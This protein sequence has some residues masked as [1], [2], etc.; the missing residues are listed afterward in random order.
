MRIRLASRLASFARLLASAGGRWNYYAEWPPSTKVD[1]T[2][3]YPAYGTEGY[4]VLPRLVV[5]G[6]DDGFHIRGI[7]YDGR[8]DTIGIE[9]ARRHYNGRGEKLQTDMAIELSSTSDRRPR[10]GGGTA[11]IPASTG[12]GVERKDSSTTVPE[13]V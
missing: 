1:G 7:W 8:T 10:Q 9:I 4:D 12:T 5:T 13:R 2:T 11:S 6:A 3:F